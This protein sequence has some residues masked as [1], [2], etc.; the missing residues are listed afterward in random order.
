LYFKKEDVIMLVDGR[1]IHLIIKGEVTR[2]DVIDSFDTRRY[3][4]SIFAPFCG[5][6]EARDGQEALEMCRKSPPDLIIT[7]VMMPVVCPFYLTT[8]RSL[9]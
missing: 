9:S 7:D 1:F 5:I 6:V 3:M 2:A 4:K 8:Q